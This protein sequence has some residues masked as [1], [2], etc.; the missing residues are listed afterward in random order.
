MI[1]DLYARISLNHVL[2]SHVKVTKLLFIEMA[3]LVKKYNAKL[4][5]PFLYA[6]ELDRENYFEYLKLNNIDIVDCTPRNGF[7]EDLIL[8]DDS[9]PNAK[10]N[11]LYSTCILNKIEEMSV[12]KINKESS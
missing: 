12:E 9:H 10:C 2:G 4:L 6:T 5:I 3:E 8:V 11:S 1:E 7:T